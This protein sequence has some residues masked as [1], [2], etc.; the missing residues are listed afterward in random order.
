MGWDSL[1]CLVEMLVFLKVVLCRKL[2]FRTQ[3]DSN[4][5]KTEDLARGS[6][7]N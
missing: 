6:I 2:L 4:D 5:Q 3:L 7:P 1:N